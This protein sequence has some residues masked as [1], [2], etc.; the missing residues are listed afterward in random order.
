MAAPPCRGSYD[1]AL[2]D[3]DG[4][5][6][7][8]SEPLDDNIA[9]LRALMSEGV[10]LL[11]LTNNASRSRRLYAEKLRRLLGAPVTE[12]SVVSSAYATAVLLRRRYGPL[13]VYVVGGPG[14]VEELALQGHVVV[15][16]TEVEECLVDAVVVGFTRCLDFTVLSYAVRAVVEC[17]A[18]LFATNDDNVLPG[19]RGYEPGA[20]ALLAAIQRAARVEA[21]VV[22]KPNPDVVEPV[23]GLLEG[24]RVVVVGDRVDTD[25]ELARRLGAEGV[26]VG[27]PGPE[28]RGWYIAVPNL[29]VYSGLPRC[30]GRV[31]RGPR[32]PQR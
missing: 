18:S 8:G 23:R 24:R 14:L 13:H 26:L 32:G 10:R 5:V 22:G 3:L 1:V 20:G 11:F 4:V 31:I 25:M 21:Y 30:G 27:A 17:G 15:T 28:R 6:W 9:G 19:S 12:D 7:R 29:K 2:V 16:E